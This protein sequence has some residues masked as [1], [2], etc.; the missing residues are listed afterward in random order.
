MLGHRRKF[1]EF[2]QRSLKISLFYVLK[3]KVAKILAVSTK[4]KTWDWDWL[5]FWFCLRLDCT[6]NE[7]FLRLAFF[8][9]CALFTGPASTNFNKFFFKIGSH[10]TIHT[11]KNCFAIMFSVFSNKRYPNRLLIFLCWERETKRKIFFSFC[12]E[13]TSSTLWNSHVE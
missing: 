9:W 12:M 1:Q 10:G 4:N 2:L 7:S 11:F 5:V 13:I 6:E 3:W 8:V